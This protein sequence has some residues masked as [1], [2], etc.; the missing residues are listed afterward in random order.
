MSRFFGLAFKQNCGD[1]RNTRV[2]DIVDELKRFHIQVDVHDP[3]VDPARAVDELRLEL[4]PAPTTGRYDAVVLAV[5]HAEFLQ[6]PPPGPRAY[7]NDGGIL[8]DVKSALPA[9]RV[10]GRL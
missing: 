2:I 3:W 4:N 1:F 10:D 5:A 7:L 6:S 9:D 8:Y